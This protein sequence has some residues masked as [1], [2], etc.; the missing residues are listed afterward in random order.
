[1][2][3][4]PF[5]LFR[6]VMILVHTPGAA[7]AAVSDVCEDKIKT[8]FFFLIMRMLGAVTYASLEQTWYFFI[9]FTFYC[10]ETS[11]SLKVS[12]VAVV[13]IKINARTMS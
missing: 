8:F 6:A 1:M 9:L 10:G 11:D 4:K 7:M 3:P 12:M 5:F 13:E 2:V